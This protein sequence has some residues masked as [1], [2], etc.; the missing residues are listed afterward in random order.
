LYI[1]IDG[2]H[3]DCRSSVL[4]VGD[5]AAGGFVKTAGLPIDSFPLAAGPE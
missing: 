3:T 1:L 4:S 2:A 5:P